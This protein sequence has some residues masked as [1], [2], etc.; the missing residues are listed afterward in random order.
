MFIANG[1]LMST[2]QPTFQKGNNP[3]NPRHQFRG[4]LLPFLYYSHI[5]LV[6][7]LINTLISRPTVRMNNGTRTDT[8]YD[9]WMKALTGSILNTPY[10]DT[11]DASAVFLRRHGNN[12]FALDFPPVKPLFRATPVRFVHFHSAGE[13]VPSRTNHRTS[14]FMKP[15]PSRFV[16]AKPQNA[17]KPKC[18]RPGFLACYPPD[19]PKPHG[20]RFARV[21]EYRACCR[22]NPIFT[23]RANQQIPFRRP[24]LK[25]T[26][27]RANKPFR[28][29]QRY[30]VFMARSF[31]RKPG[32]QFCKGP[33]V[34]L[35]EYTY[36]IL[37]LLESSK[38]PLSMKYILE[39][40]EF[41][42]IGINLTKAD[43]SA[44]RTTND[45]GSSHGL[46]R[47]ECFSL[48][49]NYVFFHCFGFFAA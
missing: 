23:I 41:I 18:A 45:L 35:H 13:T 19:R 22:R 31:R 14:Q 39:S 10:P 20:Q 48:F 42:A 34:V 4:G 11:P 44:S 30:E 9:K 2:H 6:S 32:F 25:T 5:M 47:P 12:R 15:R 3:M 8:L 16:T 24:H 7:K 28:P 43:F 37:G 38:Y 36:Y 17:L 1:S 46:Y 49:H 21:L 26:A 29:P 33:W 27:T 40:R